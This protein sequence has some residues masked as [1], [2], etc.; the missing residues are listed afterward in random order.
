MCFLFTDV[1]GSTAIQRGVGDATWA[2]LQRQMTAVVRTAV[3]EH[4]GVLV[5]TEGDGCFA[6][7]PDANGAVAAC[8]DAQRELHVVDWGPARVRVRM[9]LHAG[10]DI[11]PGGRDYVALAVSQAARV[12]SA[13]HGGQVLM[14]GVVAARLVGEQPLRDLG[15]FTV[16]DFDGPTRLFELELADEPSRPPRVPATFDPHLPAFRTA[17][18]GRD[19]EIAA[20]REA[21][22]G[23]ARLV[24][25]I[26]ASGIGKTRLAVAA[27]A[28]LSGDMRAGPWFADLGAVREA[29]GIG[30]AISLATGC[31][32][33][34]EL[35]V[36]LDAALD[37]RPGVLVLD[38]CGHLRDAAASAARLLLEW[39]PTLRILVTSIEPLGSD[40]EVVIAVSG[41]SVPRTGDPADVLDSDAGRLFVER[42]ERLR[43]GFELTPSSA[44]ATA[45]ICTV[46][47]GVPLAIELAAAVST[48][49]APEQLAGVLRHTTVETIVQWSLDS[50]SEEELAAL[51]ALSI[52]NLAVDSRLA[53]AAVGVA[54][55]DVLETLTA[56]GLLDLD[57]DGRYRVP[58]PVRAQAD[59]SA[60]QRR[61][62]LQRL[63]EACLA[64][65][66]EPPV[67]L[68]IH[69][70]FAPLAAV[71]L[72]E[73]ALAVSDRQRLAAQ[74][75]P[76]WLG[77]LGARRAREHLE[78]ALALG[79][80][81]AAAAAL[82]LVL[83][84]ALA[85]LDTQAAEQHLSAAARLLGESDAVDPALV[86]RL[87]SI[88]S[89]AT[90]DEAG[91]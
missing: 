62:V 83:A 69:E 86:E 30:D 1:E 23:S 52:V 2:Q 78:A 72:N 71:L 65:T 53:A 47:D 44:R 27:V 13:A 51:S 82:H 66:A 91:R 50:L 42:A 58:A 16:R 77:R 9:G 10:T 70:S 85:T 75:A 36:H 3:E 40:D 20:V 35:D 55:S 46:F 64:G 63:L 25:L 84:D 43:P 39:C 32:P 26:G 73:A 56:R 61:V 90:D 88:A 45:T 89:S 34:A 22:T 24:T 80:T 38:D 33:D 14:S 79:D 48:R 15:L 8:L 5:S 29:H 21:L 7:F 67:P 81:G 54:D 59:A 74:L 41:L 4:G 17:M 28:Q 18:V 19:P 31:P 60:E 11:T 68:S 76:W 57:E 37:D 6:A 12:C 87:K 49:V